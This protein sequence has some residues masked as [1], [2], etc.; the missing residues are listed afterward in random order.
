MLIFIAIVIR[1]CDRV[2][3]DVSFLK[4]VVWNSLYHSIAWDIVYVSA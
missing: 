2:D 4:D 3:L 1:F